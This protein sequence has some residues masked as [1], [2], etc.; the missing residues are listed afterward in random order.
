MIPQ[1][2]QC[3][4]A[5]SLSTLATHWN[6]LE[7]FA[8]NPVSDPILNHPDK[9]KWPLGMGPGHGAVFMT[10]LVSVMCSQDC[11][12]MV[13]AEVGVWPSLWN[14]KKLSSS[15]SHW[16]LRQ[17]E[18]CGL[19]YTLTKTSTPILNKMEKVN[20]IPTTRNQGL[21]YKTCVAQ[22]I[23]ALLSTLINLAGDSIA[24]WCHEAV[25]SSDRLIPIAQ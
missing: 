17:K 15:N 14:L 16:I 8:T 21:F 23:H 3:N 19:L 18:K 25:D 5:K 7:S 13:W 2:R 20:K 9:G 10:P 1:E 12:S 24:M 22:S 4:V 6:K 11:E